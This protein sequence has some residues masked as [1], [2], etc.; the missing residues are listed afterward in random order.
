MDCDPRCKCISSIYGC[1]RLASTSY[2]RLCILDDDEAARADATDLRDLSPLCTRLSES[3]SLLLPDVPSS[4]NK[5]SK[6]TIT[7]LTLQ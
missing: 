4:A 2:L 3:N 6:D 1:L 7:I 5:Y